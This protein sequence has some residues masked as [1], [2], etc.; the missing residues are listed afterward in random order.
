MKLKFVWLIPLASTLFAGNSGALPQVYREGVQYQLVTPPLS[1]TP[2]GKVEVVEFLWYG[3]ET[4]YVIQPDLARWMDKRKDAIDYQRMPAVTN[5]DM[6]LM[7]RA[8]YTAEALGISEQIH[9]ALFA[10]IHRYR[11][12]LNTEDDLAAFFAEHGVSEQDFHQTFRSSFVA[13]KVRKAKTMGDRYGIA[14]APTIV[15]NGKYRVDSSMV[16]N[17]EEFIAVI[18]F[19]VNKE[20]SNNI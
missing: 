16:V 8:F 4:C 10:A 13:G 6:V 15:I 14:G 19:L 7:A 2:N 5:N 9:Q 12:Q 17:P 1:H 20:I 11:Q 18:D 3:C